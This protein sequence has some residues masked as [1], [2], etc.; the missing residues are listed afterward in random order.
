MRLGRD[1]LADRIV[2]PGP[3]RAAS[4]VRR[5]SQ[6]TAGGAKGETGLAGTLDPAQQPGVVQTPAIEGLDKGGFGVRVRDQVETVAGMV[7]HDIRACSVAQTRTST[8][9]SL[10]S[11]SISTQRSGNRR[12][13]SRKPCRNRS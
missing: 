4:R 8:S 13:M 1:Q 5:G 10:P 3:Q 9:S 7:T 12:A 2:R 11:A 6:Q